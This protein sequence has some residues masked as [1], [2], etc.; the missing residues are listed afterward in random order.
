MNTSTLTGAGLIGLISF[1]ALVAASTVGLV[2]GHL[3][4]SD[5]TTINLT[6]AGLTG[7]V[8]TAHVVGTQVNNAATPTPTPQPAPVLAPTQAIPVTPPVS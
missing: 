5:W 3:S 4:S 2:T 1:V 7:I 6:A 8:G